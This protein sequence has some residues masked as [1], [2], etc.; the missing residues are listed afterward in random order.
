MAMTLLSEM[1]DMTELYRTDLICGV[2]VCMT[3]VVIIIVAYFA[4]IR[5]VESK[6]AQEALLFV[7]VLAVLLAMSALTC[8]IVI[9]GKFDHAL[10][11]SAAA[12]IENAGELLLQNRF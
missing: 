10:K 2:G 12:V 7:S 4:I 1:G 3:A 8:K 5:H 9:L 6:A 11:G